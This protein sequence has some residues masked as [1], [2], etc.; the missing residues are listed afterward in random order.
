MKCLTVAG[1]AVALQ[2]CSSSEKRTSSSSK[3]SLAA[4][5]PHSEA[6][7]S[8]KFP[9]H[10][11]KVTPKP[12]EAQGTS[13]QLTDGVTITLPGE[14]SIVKTY[15]PKRLKAYY[16]HSQ[17]DVGLLDVNWADFA[18]GDTGVEASSQWQAYRDDTNTTST[19]VQVDWP[20]AEEA[21]AWTWDQVADFSELDSSLGKGASNLSAVSMVLRTAREQDIYIAA[22][23]PEGS[24]ADSPAFMALNSLSF[25]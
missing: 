24:L 18:H 1:A 20:N 6:S 21:W 9:G 14:L 16:F 11:L 19:L 5:H 8:G 12:K 23:S 17:D 13:R 25:S 7:D 10:A 4:S 15:G 2:A 22:Y 3:G